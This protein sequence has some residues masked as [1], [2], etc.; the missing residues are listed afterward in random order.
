MISAGTR[1]A[2]FIL[3]G[4]VKCLSGATGMLESVARVPGGAVTELKHES[5]INSSM[6]R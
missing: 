5:A 4:T 3:F 6:V 2:R 1:A